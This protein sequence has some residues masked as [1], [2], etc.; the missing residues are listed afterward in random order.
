MSVISAGASARQDAGP[1]S[2]EGF[3]SRTAHSQR[4]LSSFSSLSAEVLFHLFSF[5]S[6]AE[7]L[8]NVTS[9]CRRF[10]SFL[11]TPLLYNA[12]RDQF[13]SSPNWVDSILMWIKGSRLRC[14][15]TTQCDPG[16]LLELVLSDI[17]KSDDPAIRSA[18]GLSVFVFRGE[19]SPKLLRQILE[20]L[21]PEWEQG[22]FSNETDVL[23][24][25][26]D[27]NVSEESLRVLDEYKVLRIL[28]LFTLAYSNANAEKVVAALDRGARPRWSL[29]YKLVDYRPIVDLMLRHGLAIDFHAFI[30]AGENID[31]I[32]YLFD[33]L[34]SSGSAV[35][36]SV[37]APA[38]IRAC[39]RRD[40][41]AAECFLAHGADI[42]LGSIEEGVLAPPIS[43][44]LAKRDPWDFVEFLLA[45]GS[46]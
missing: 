24:A 34:A 38:F 13:A 41:P 39:E 32:E 43:Y 42:N 1:T 28:N 31:V 11:T 17:L 44:V 29:A 2:G 16:D 5:L 10:V 9:T 37:L 21:S 45:R 36:P 15:E 46:P 6:R 30:C 40:V 4:S 35:D 22:R 19:K 26:V 7:D 20:N 8:R 12:L 33:R 23:Q 14:L 3:S 25:I 18:T 27:F